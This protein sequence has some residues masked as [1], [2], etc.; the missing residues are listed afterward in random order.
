[1]IVIK[2]IFA[3]LLLLIVTAF[4]SLVA[5]MIALTVFVRREGNEPVG[6]DPISVVRNTPI[7]W[8]VAAV[9]FLLGFFWEFRRT[10]SQ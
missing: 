9:I 3:G 7:L 10:N 4:L 5:A 8:V 6:I 2:S 1:M